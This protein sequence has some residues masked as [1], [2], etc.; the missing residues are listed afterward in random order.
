MYYEY[1]FQAFPMPER[2]FP[3]DF[4]GYQHS[5]CLQPHGYGE[6]IHM[7]LVLKIKLFQRVQDNPQ[8]PIPYYYEYY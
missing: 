2:A 8:F 1:V 7:V 6:D 3:T 4:N 5:C